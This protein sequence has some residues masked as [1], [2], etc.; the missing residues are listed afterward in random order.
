MAATMQPLPGRVR[1]STGMRQGHTLG[2]TLSAPHLL[3]HRAT[4]SVRWCTSNTAW[5]GGVDAPTAGS[6]Q[7]LL[8][9]GAVVFLRGSGGARRHGYMAA[10]PNGDTAAWPNGGT[11]ARRHG[12]MATRRHGSMAAW[13]RGS[14][15]A[16][17]YGRIAA[18]RHGGMA[19][20]RLDGMAA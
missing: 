14:M 5:T 11:A 12:R 6:L 2:A 15:T 20:W 9:V 17:R 3:C 13:R 7:R 8:H 19:E 4:L 1:Q 16:W 18:R 10:W